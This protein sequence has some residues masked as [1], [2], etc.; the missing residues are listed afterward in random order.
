[1][2]NAALGWTFYFGIVIVIMGFVAWAWVR[3][4]DRAMRDWPD[5]RGEDLFDDGRACEPPKN[6]QTE[7]KTK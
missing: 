1:M 6:K 3:G 7:N 5:Y 2:E 4:I